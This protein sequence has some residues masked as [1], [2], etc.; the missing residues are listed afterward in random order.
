MAAESKAAAKSVEEAR[1][2]VERAT[3]E[4]EKLFGQ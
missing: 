2:T 4:L 3:K 1:R